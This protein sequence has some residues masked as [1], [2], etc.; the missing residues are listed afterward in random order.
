MP[1][2]LCHPLVVLDKAALRKRMRMVCDLVDDRTM[3][4]VDLWSRLALLPEYAEA[5]TVMAFAGTDREVD[6]DPLLARLAHDGKGIVLPRVVGDDIEP[7]LPG[8]SWSTGAFGIREPTG[9]AVDPLTI[10]LVVVPGVAFTL[11]GARL[12]HGKGFYDRF[13]TALAASGHRPPAIG[14]CFAEQ[15]VDALPVEPHDV[16]LQRVLWA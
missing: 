10:D 5:R 1:S 7:A 11:D 9:A 12:G 14:V 6:T 13:L 15:V 2:C 16:R 4:S 8:D 3:R